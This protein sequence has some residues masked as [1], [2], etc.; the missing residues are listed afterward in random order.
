LGEGSTDEPGDVEGTRLDS[1]LIS[2][3]GSTR[4]PGGVR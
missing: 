2:S 4:I 3:H 1:V